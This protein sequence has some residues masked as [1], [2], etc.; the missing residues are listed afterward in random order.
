MLNT[1]GDYIGW[2]DSNMGDLAF[3]FP[4][5]KNQLND[6]DLILLS[7]YIEGGSDQRNKMRVLSSELINFTCNIF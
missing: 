6:Y 7:R 1:T 3:H 4:E 2:I 5:M